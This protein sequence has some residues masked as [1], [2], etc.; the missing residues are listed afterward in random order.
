MVSLKDCK[1]T[2]KSTWREIWYNCVTT[3]NGFW[4]DYLG[5]FVGIVISPGVCVGKTLVLRLVSPLT[6]RVTFNFCTF[7]SGGALQERKGIKVTIL[8]KTLKKKSV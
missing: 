4:G 7:N 1:E 3:Q 8:Y 5:M 2:L 6:Q